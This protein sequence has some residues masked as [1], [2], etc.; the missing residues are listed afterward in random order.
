[1]KGLFL[2]LASFSEGLEMLSPKKD[3]NEFLKNENRKNWTQEK[4]GMEMG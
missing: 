4:K 3:N 1:M 2:W